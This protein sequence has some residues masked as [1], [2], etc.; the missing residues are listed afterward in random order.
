MSTV[1]APPVSVG[2]VALPGRIVRLAT[3]PAGRRF[4]ASDDTQMHGLTITL[5]VHFSTLNVSA[6]CAMSW[7]ALDDFRDKTW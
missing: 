6:F 3:V 1:A 5:V 4:V 7:D 2:V